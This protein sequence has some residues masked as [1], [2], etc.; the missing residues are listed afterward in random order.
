MENNKK[1]IKKLSL[2]NFFLSI[3]GI[4]YIWS[5]PLLA[6][7]GFAEKNK[8]S[9]SGF[10]SNPQATGAMAVISYL[11]ITL[12]WEYQAICIK[13][14]QSKCSGIYLL[15]RT[16][17]LFNIFYGAFLICSVS[18]VPL[19]LHMTTVV[20]FCATYIARCFYINKYININKITKIILLIGI[21]AGILLLF[22]KN[23]WFWAC[24]CIGFTSMLLYTPIDWLLLQYNHKIKEIKINPSK[25]KIVFKNSNLETIK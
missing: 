10:I 25:E 9:I 21:L 1:P 7:L 19:W 3:I 23:M 4:F 11:P 17:I 22:V 6:H 8:S 13:T 24:E 14:L 2:L 16:L 12:M 18:Y 20:I 15:N 5:L